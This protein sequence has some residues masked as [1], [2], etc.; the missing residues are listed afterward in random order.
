VDPGDTSIDELLA[1][2]LRNETAPWPVD[3]PAPDAIDRVAIVHGIAGLLIERAPL[4]AKW[5]PELIARLREQARAQAMWEVRHRQLLM[6][7]LERLEAQSIPCLILKGTAVAYDLYGNPS[8]RARGDTDLL[9][10][11]DD[12]AN[13]KSILAA[14]GFTG[15]TLGGVTDEF[16]L[17]QTW[18]LALSDGGRH[19]IDLHW[20]VMNAPSLSRLF[21]FQE[22]WAHSRPLHRLSPLARTMDLARLLIHT[23]LHRAMQNNSPYFVAGETYFEPGRLIWTYDINLLAAALSAE[24]WSSLVSL[25][26]EMGVARPCLGGL[27]AAEATLGTTLPDGQIR[28]LEALAL[29]AP[30]SRYFARSHPLSRAWQDVG[31]VPGILP[32]LRYALSRIVTT[33]EFLRSKYPGLAHRPLPWLYGRRL[34]DAMRRRPDAS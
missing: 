19:S 33:E 3:E 25:A 1:A 18:T 16:A 9:I 29:N 23:C 34:L 13:A 26:G 2:A 6:G 7:L 21:D 22:C 8:S 28:E 10:S 24:E 31:A 4:V 12:V 20:Q 11:V 27:R 32:K 5:P 14:L 15:E 30:G 17:Q